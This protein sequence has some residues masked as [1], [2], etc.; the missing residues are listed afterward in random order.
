MKPA[1]VP[2]DKDLFY[3]SKTRYYASGMI[4]SVN[5]EYERDR[6]GIRR[7]V[8]LCQVDAFTDRAFT[9]NPADVVPDATGCGRA[10]FRSVHGKALGRRGAADIE[11]VVESCQ[12]VRVRVGGRA[13][14]V[15]SGDLEL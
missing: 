13:V 3:S 6:E 4:R 9:G 1:H 5:P 7:R 2:D 11:V 12:P 10:R 15:F 14:V 8:R